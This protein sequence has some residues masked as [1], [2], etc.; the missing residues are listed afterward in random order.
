M[1][2]RILITAIILIFSISAFSQ[3]V[4]EKRQIKTTA[5]TMYENYK[6]EIRGLHSRSSITEDNFLALFDSKAKIYNDILPDNHSQQ[7]SPADYFSIFRANINR[8]YPDFSDFKMGEPV[9][10]GNKWQIK[11]NFTRATRFKTHKNMNYP[12]WSFNYSMT[13]EMDKSYNNS[14]KVY[15]NAKIVNIEVDNPLGKFFVIENKDNIPLVT[16]FGKPITEWDK[17][18]QS[19][20]FT[21]K[22]WTI[23]D[24]QVSESNNLEKIF[25]YS[26]A[27][28]VKNR[29]DELFYHIDIQ[30]YMK[31]LFGISIKYCMAN[32]GNQ[33]SEENAE[34]FKNFEHLSNATSFSFFYGKQLAN[35]EKST[36]FLNFGLDLNIY[37]HEYSGANDTTTYYTDDVDGDYYWRK[38]IINSL[39]EKITNVTV[40][41]PLSIQYLRQLTNQTKNPIFI[42][43]EFGVFAETSLSLRSKYDLDVEYSGLYEKYFGVEF[44]H[45]YDFG[46]FPDESGNQKLNSYFNGGWFGSVGLWYALNNSNLLKLDVSYKY[47][48]LPPSE[49]KSK[50]VISEKK[51]SYNSLI[52]STNQGLRNVYFGVSWAKTIGGKK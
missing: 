44:T 2:T 28:F 19:R 35:K 39:H 9:S 50:Y 21:E 13:I 31:N 17:E 12:E 43:F 48:F 40:S 36:W 14:K 34:N 5:L 24:I 3:S 38:I 23:R 7:L 11:C 33:F 37:N 42:A 41:V 47:S 15:E 49:Y 1:R 16:R 8:I 51:D 30:R 27:Q 29:D 45:Y 6:G 22:E 25:V 20:I 4:T 18:Y 10:V 46:S 26:T 32:M 52:Y